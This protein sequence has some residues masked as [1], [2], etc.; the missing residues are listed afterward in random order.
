[1]IRALER[2][3]FD[4]NYNGFPPEGF[5]VFDT[6]TYKMMDNSNNKKYYI[7]HTGK[8]TDRYQRAVALDFVKVCLADAEDDLSEYGFRII[9]Q[10]SDGHKIYNRWIKD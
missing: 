7:C 2:V 4:K 5:S 3:H 9:G 8:D 1:M 6:K 10:V